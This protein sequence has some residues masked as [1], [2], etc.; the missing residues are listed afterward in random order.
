MSVSPSVM[1]WASPVHP[2]AAARRAH[3][4]SLLQ[5]SHLVRSP[6]AS[7][8]LAL[9]VLHSPALLPGLPATHRH[10]AQPCLSSRPPGRSQQEPTQLPASL[11]S[12]TPGRKWASLVGAVV[13]S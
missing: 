3:L 2:T 11:C 10:L 8:Q 9:W 13:V 5:L 4:L 1:V 6:P 7:Q 12:L